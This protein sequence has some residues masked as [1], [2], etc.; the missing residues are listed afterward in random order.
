ML[1]ADDLDAAIA[2]E[3]LFKDERVS[4]YWDSERVLGQLVSQT[5]KLASLVA[6]DIYLLYS[7]GAMWK[8][9]RIPTPDFWMHQLNERPDLLL[10]PER[11]MAEVQKVI[12]TTSKVEFIN[13]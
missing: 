5:L 9:E 6:W 3:A 13:D 8:G 4:Q 7:P 10:D 11:L 1:T 12:D 2:Q